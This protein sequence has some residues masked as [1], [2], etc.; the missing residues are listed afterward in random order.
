MLREY[1]LRYVEFLKLVVPDIEVNMEIWKQEMCFLFEVLIMAKE[2]AFL[3]GELVIR[4]TR[5]SAE[6]LRIY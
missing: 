2:E 3:V 4:L 1:A 6:L 5:I